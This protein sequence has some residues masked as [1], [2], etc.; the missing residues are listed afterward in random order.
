MNE[1]NLINAMHDAEIFGIA[2]CDSGSTFKIELLGVDRKLFEFTLIDCEFF[3]MV[4]LTP[5]SIVS[6]LNVYHGSSVNREY[7]YSR[8]RWMTGR[9]DAV[10]HL[11]DA[12]AEFV[13]QGILNSDFKLVVI[14]PSSGMEFSC[15]CR[16]YAFKEIS[17]KKSV[18]KQ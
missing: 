6:Q 2:L 10:S 1:T 5:R 16:I 7:V 14:T 11:K 8:L 15:I 13:F 4:D 17:P 3:R 18:Q 9:V 12:D